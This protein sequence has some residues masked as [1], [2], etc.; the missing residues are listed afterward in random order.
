M[1]AKFPVEKS[2]LR[3]FLLSKQALLEAGCSD[4]LQMVKKLECVQLD[5]VSV[6]ERNQHLVLASRIPGYE[7]RHLD[8]LLAEGKV[9][10][11]FANAACV[12]PMEDFPLFEPTRK[13]IQLKVA[14]SLEK[15]GLV[16]DAV[17]EQLRSEGP[18]PSR[19]FQSEK[20][21]HGYWDNK[22][23]KTK[24]TSLALNLLLDSGIIRVVRRDRTERYF[25]LTERT[26]SSDLL[27]KTRAME[28]ETARKMLID[29]YLRAYSVFEPRDPRFGWQ[30]LKAVERRA[31]VERRVD[32]GAV[33][34]LEV[35]GT[36]RQ[37][38][39]LAEDMDELGQFVGDGKSLE[40][41]ATFLSPLDN[42]L[43]SRERIKDLFEFD[44]KWE[45]YTPR[46]K[47][48]YGPYAMPILYGDRL[49]GRM[50]PQIDRKNEVLIV[51]LLQLEPW[52]EKTTELR[53]A[54]RNALEAFAAFNGAK[55]IH[56]EQADL[57]I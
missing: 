29:K 36:E 31:E 27:E 34:P 45:I 50:D 49:I 55:D 52:V 12:I 32:A 22:L 3:R 6:V 9:F 38:Y 47:R 33:I 18:L 53:D 51:R 44:Y 43:W 48:K 8:G 19:A 56:L 57:N 37:Y 25:D 40:G 23:P 41:T 7:T 10:E 39:M 4:A 14:E 46:S 54:I 15:L 17:I 13:R 5:P 30:K 35:D 11:Y 1:T 16:V 2:A 24:E 21:V 26:V 20:R 28:E 42:L